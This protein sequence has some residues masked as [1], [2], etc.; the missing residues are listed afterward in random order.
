MELIDSDA[1]DSELHH[2]QRKSHVT[3]RAAGRR[4]V[5]GTNETGLGKYLARQTRARRQSSP[6]RHAF[7]FVTMTFYICLKS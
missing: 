7:R 6:I 3:W 1:H 4:Q 5:G 2:S